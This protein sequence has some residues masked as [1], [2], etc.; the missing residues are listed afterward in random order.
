ME[1]YITTKHNTQTK[2]GY[3][4]CRVTAVTLTVENVASFN[5]S[6]WDN[7]SKRPSSSY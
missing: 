5:S 2:T 6:E 4:Q 7:G 3:G 1:H